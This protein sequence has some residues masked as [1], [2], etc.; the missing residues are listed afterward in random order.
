VSDV[1]PATVNHVR[2]G[3][4]PNALCGHP[5]SSDVVDKASTCNACVSLLVKAANTPTWVQAGSK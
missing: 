4:S 5:I 2:T 1:D 3:K